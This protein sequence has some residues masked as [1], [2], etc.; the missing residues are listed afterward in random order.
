VADESGSDA[1]VS[2]VEQ[3]AAT[4]RTLIDGALLAELGRRLYDYG[5]AIEWNTSCTSCAR[6]LD[7]SIAEYERAERAEAKLAAIEAL[8]RDARASAPE[9]VR[10]PSVAVVRILA[11]MGSD[12]KG[13]DRG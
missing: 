4:A 11:I 13:P 7:T 8:A 9:S 2:R 1:P 5:N 10:T 6:V 12:E 3:D